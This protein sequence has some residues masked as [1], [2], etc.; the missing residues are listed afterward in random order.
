MRK[1]V[2]AAA[3]LLCIIP[4]IAQ[5]GPKLMVKKWV[6]SPTVVETAARSDRRLQ[7]N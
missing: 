4:S 6:A 7:G 2:L 5:A 3:A 1:I